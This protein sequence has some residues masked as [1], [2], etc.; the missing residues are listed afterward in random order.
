LSKPITPQE[1]HEHIQASI[2]GRPSGHSGERFDLLQARLHELV[3]MPTEIELTRKFI[4]RVMHK[5]EQYD[6]TTGS[7]HSCLAAINDTMFEMEEEAGI[8]E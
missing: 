8:D 5:M 4:E 7:Q 6:E 3:D 2:F 1:L